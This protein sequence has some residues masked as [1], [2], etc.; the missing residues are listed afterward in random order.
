MQA[1]FGL[2]VGADNIAKT[3]PYLESFA[4][5]RGSASSIFRIIDRKTRIDAMSADGKVLNFGIRGHIRY[6]AVDFSY[7]SR[8]EAAVLRQLSVDIRAGQTVALVGS[9]GSGKSTCLQL[10]Q[11]FY[12]PGAG[13]VCIDGSDIRQ[14]N[15]AWLRSNIGV[16]GQ[17][18]VL[19]STTIGENIRYGKPDASDKEV[20]NAA[21]DSG[22]HDFIARLPNVSVRRCDGVAVADVANTQCG[23][24][25]T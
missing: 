8:P 13:G 25:F 6:E 19:F 5:A 11:R 10:L 20:E 14:F 18:P 7:P 23:Q 3:A 9:S 24:R 12:D 15:I 4:A 1:F 16:V 17:E 21:K 22:A 2:I